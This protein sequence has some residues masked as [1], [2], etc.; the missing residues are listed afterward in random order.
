M[1]RNHAALMVALRAAFP[2]AR[3]TEFVG[4]QHSMAQSIALFGEADVVVAPHGAALGFL[5]F[6]RPTAACVEVRT[7]ERRKTAVW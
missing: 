3:V 5:A 4:D 6:M 1:L 7:D 2:T